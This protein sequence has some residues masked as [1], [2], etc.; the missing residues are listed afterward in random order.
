MRERA[1]NETSSLRN[2]RLV[3]EI[4]EGRRKTTGRNA[5]ALASQRKLVGNGGSKVEEHDA[6]R[7]FFAPKVTLVSAIFLRSNMTYYEPS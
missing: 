6:E 3:F 2:I 7:H 1:R 5:A 4:R